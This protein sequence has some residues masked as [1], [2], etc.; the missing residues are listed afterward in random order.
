M[1]KI[2]ENTPG[3]TALIEGRTCLYFSGFSY[4]GMHSSH[5]FRDLL[6]VGIG[7]FGS[8]Y[9]S[10]RISNMQL[11]LYEEVEHALAAL[12]QQQ[13]A[14]CFSSGYLA[15]QA[16]I[17]YATTKGEILF[18]P[19]THPSLQYPGALVPVGHWQDWITTVVE[20]VNKGEDHQ[21]VIVADAVNPLTATVNDFEALR[22]I[23]KKV[24]VLIDDSHGV[25]ILGEKGEGSI[26][27]LPDSPALHYMIAASMAKAFSLEGG[28]IAGHAADVA[29]I[30]RSPIF[31]ASTPMIPAYAY[32]FL[33]AAG[34]YATAR[35][36][37]KDLIIEFKRL[38]AGING[39]HHPHQLPM[40]VLE[41]KKEKEH[42]YTY[43]LSRDTF[44]SSFAYPDP[45]G[46]RINRVV[47]SAL[48]THTDLN[49]LSTQLAQFYP[50]V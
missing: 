50:S 46:Q 28:F 8:V 15:A 41:D 4:L 37:L 29:A 24:M 21:Y 10:S 20:M 49:I 26:H 32:T 35:K 19:G 48:H 11:K 1:I 39:I 14:V 7:R 13:S 36:R 5:T 44:I 22:Q 6:A 40:F 34:A 3:R 16:A 30:R 2:T 38:N 9:P 43:L 18:A 42:V 47:L 12:L 25:G 33:H 45:M 27:I 23:E 31:T 17:T